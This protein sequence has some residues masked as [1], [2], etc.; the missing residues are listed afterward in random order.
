MYNKSTL[1]DL[2]V[3]EKARVGEL[4]MRGSLRRRLMELGVQKGKQIQCAFKSPLGRPAA[5]YVGGSLIALR[6]SDAR[7]IYLL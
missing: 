5:Y 1:C 2:A 4:C 6:E 3:G 7:E